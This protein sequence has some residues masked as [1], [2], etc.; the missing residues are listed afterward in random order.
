MIDLLFL[1]RVID[2][3]LLFLLLWLFFFLVNVLALHFI[4]HLLDLLDRVHRLYLTDHGPQL[5]LAPLI[6]GPLLCLLE[7]GPNA[8]DV[9]ISDVDSVLRHLT[10]VIVVRFL[11]LS[12]PCL[13][14]EVGFG[15]L[16]DL[17]MTRISVFPG[18][19]FG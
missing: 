2:L 1:F 7:V 13:F 8:V 15:D 17:G 18:E 19:Y 5:P 16:G 12:R 9:L 6:R 4:L 10:H 11:L 3:F 14:V